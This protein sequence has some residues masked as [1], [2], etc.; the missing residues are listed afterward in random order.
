MQF[1]ISALTLLSLIKLTIAAD[2]D[3]G[4]T[5]TITTTPVTTELATVTA[6]EDIYGTVYIYTAD[7]GQ[8]TTQTILHTEL[9]PYEPAQSTTDV[10]ASSSTPTS[11]TT[12]SSS[13]DALVSSSTPASSDITTSSTPTSSSTSSSSLVTS[14]ESVIV[15]PKGE[16]SS[17]TKITNTILPNGSTAILEL[18]VLYTQEC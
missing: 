5:T 1:K 16:Y 7:N 11:T 8:L 4:A 12:T 9:N 3:A 10:P 18:V 13:L 14:S 6:Q 17:S 2:D 15:I